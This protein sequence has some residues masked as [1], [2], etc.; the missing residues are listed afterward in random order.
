MKTN[1]EYIKLTEKFSANN[2]HPLSIVLNRGKPMIINGFHA[3]RNYKEFEKSLKKHYSE[4]F[5]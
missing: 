3:K 2:Y 1:K 4:K 5:I